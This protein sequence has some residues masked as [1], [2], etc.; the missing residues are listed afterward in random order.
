MSVDRGGEATSSSSSL[1]YLCAWLT[2]ALFLGIVVV[3]TTVAVAVAVADANANANVNTNTVLLL[4]MPFCVYA[5]CSPLSPFVLLHIHTLFVPYD[6]P[7]VKCTT[8][9]T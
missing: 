5:C 7:L 4:L 3:A 1:L 2:A 9:Q 8:I 6:R